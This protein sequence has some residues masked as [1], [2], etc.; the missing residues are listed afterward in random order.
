ML[1]VLALAAF[2]WF[3][4]EIFLT[5]NSSSDLTKRGRVK[6]GFEA[7]SL[8]HGLAPGFQRHPQEMV[9]V[10]LTSLQRQACLFLSSPSVYSS[11]FFS[12]LKHLVM[13]SIK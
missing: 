4:G 13:R 10:L 12:P 3:P 7:F 6:Y 2:K 9:V 1:F 5:E 8:L 11:T